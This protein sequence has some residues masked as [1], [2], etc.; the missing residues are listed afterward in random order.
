MASQVTSLIANGAF[1]RF[2]SLRVLLVGGGVTWINGALRRANI[3]WRA[4]RAEVPWVRKLPEEYFHE[5]FRVS[6]YGIERGPAQ[7]SLRA[8]LELNPDHRDLLVYGSGYPSW[9]TA[10]P[11]EIEDLIPG[12]WRDAVMAENSDKLFRWESPVAT[13]RSAEAGVV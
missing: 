7:A 6:T 5:H 13:G 10:S 2:P 9:D 8:Y 3:T 11:A 1:E 4:F 12:D